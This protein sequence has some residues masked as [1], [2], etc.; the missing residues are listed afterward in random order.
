MS[1]HTQFKTYSAIIMAV[2]YA[3]IDRLIVEMIVAPLELVNSDKDL[4][5]SDGFATCSIT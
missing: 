1:K 3:L 4:Q 2:A 5:N